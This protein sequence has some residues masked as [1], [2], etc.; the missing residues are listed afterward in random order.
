MTEIILSFSVLFKDLS[1]D[2]LLTI[3]EDTDALIDVEHR[4]IV[5]ST[6]PTGMDS[7]KQASSINLIDESNQEI[8]LSQ[9]FNNATC[10]SKNFISI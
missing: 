2:Q 7:I 3:E 10:E 5:P 6:N 9:V 1:S 4:E 8:Y